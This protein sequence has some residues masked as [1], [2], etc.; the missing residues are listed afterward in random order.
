[1]IPLSVGAQERNVENIPEEEL[2]AALNSDETESYTF[3]EALRR[4]EIILFGSLPFAL[5]FTNIVYDFGRYFSFGFSE[6][7]SSANAQS[8][9][10]QLFQDS[11][12]S[13]DEKTGVL[14]VALSASLV[15]AIVDLIIELVK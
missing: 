1:M 10:I 7:F 11:A 2:Q 9:Q 8:N 15:I 3:L 14:L 12:R 5:L 13:D 6:G 4:F